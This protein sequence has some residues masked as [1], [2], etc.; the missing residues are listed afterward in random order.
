MLNSFLM[1]FSLALASLTLWMVISRVVRSLGQ[2]TAAMGKIAGGETSVVV[3]CTT[4]RDEMGSMAR[5]L[6]VFK[7]NAVKVLQ[8]AVRRLRQRGDG[9]VGQRDRAAGAGI[10]ENRR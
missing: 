9:L 5:A 7:E 8:C 10:G 2:I 1:A 6:L 3:P 4:R